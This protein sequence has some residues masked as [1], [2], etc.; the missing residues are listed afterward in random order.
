MYNIRAYMYLRVVKGTV[1]HEEKERERERERE[2]EQNRRV[3]CFPRIQS[4][5]GDI[6]SNIE[7]HYT[8]RSG[9]HLINTYYSVPK[10]GHFRRKSLNAR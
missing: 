8:R 1:V 9:R 10:H 6:T 5:P 4:R 3:I 7:A 2:G